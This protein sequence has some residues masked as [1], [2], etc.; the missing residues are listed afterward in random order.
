MTVPAPGGGADTLYAFFSHARL[1]RVMSVTV[2]AT[3]LLSEGIRPLIGWPYPGGARRIA[4]KRASLRLL[5][6]AQTSRRREV[7]KSRC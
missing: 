5:Y 3:V 1:A 4:Q 2:L 7:E 6:N